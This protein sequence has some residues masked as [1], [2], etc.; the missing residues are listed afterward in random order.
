MGIIAVLL[1]A[2]RII[3]GIV[4]LIASV[5][6]IRTI[7]T[8]RDKTVEDVADKMNKNLIAVAVLAIAQAVLYVI[9]VI[10]K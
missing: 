3:L 1:N 10:L 7:K 9:S 2:L 6:L 4:L 5:N 8:N